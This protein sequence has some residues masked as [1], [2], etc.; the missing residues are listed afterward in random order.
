MTFT[1][2][3]LD[4]AIG[5]RLARYQ[6]KWE[7]ERQHIFVQAVDFTFPRFGSVSDIVDKIVQ[8]DIPYDQLIREFATVLGRG[9]VHISFTMISTCLR[10]GSIDQDGARAYA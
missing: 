4:A 6:R 3:E 10:G 2:E 1:Q 7:L 5:K 9:W 8:S